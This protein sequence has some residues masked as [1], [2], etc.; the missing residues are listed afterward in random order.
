MQEFQCPKPAV[1]TTE[2]RGDLVTAQDRALEPR[3]YWFL[4]GIVLI[5]IVAAL[6]GTFSAMV[7]IWV[8]AETFNH[9][10]LIAPASIYLV[11]PHRKQLA[12]ITPLPSLAG[13]AA[14]GI[15]TGV[16]ML[17]DLA[18]TVVVQNFAAVALAPLS[19]WAILGTR[20]ARK[21]MFPLGYLFFMVP[22][23]YVLIP[24]LMDYTADFTVIAV[25][26][27]GVPVYRDGL[28][29]MIPGGSF[30]IVEAC[31]GIRMLIAA[32]AIGALFAY[33][34]F[35][36]WWR[37]L[38][39]ILGAAGLAI[40][41][42][43]MRAYTIVM[44][45]HYRGMDTIADHILLGYVIFAFIIVLMLMIGSRFSDIDTQPAPVIGSGAPGTI[46]GPAKHLLFAA[47]IVAIVAIT[48]FYAA[49]LKLH[50]AVTVTPTLTLP[51]ATDGWSG[52]ETVELNWAPQFIGQTS[53]LHGRYQ[54]RAA[55]VD[56]YVISYLSQTEGAEL[57]N[58][59]NQMF[60]RK[61]WLL[62]RDATGTAR[63]ADGKSLDY[64]E[65]E[66]YSTTGSRRLVRYWY[67]VDGRPQLS[68]FAVKLRELGNTLIGRPTSG[69]LV[70][71]SSHAA[72]GTASA[73]RTLD[74]FM[75]ATL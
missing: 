65:I 6:S 74:D 37:R 32:V 3:F 64:R 22:V 9:C 23:G 29:F 50:S 18:S 69:S 58:T 71:V 28:I 20:I 17:G 66:I 8:E 26:A 34:N 72:G 45:G 75:A 52:P 68:Q 4:A 12:A 70:A 14:V 19:I 21:I 30:K 35:Y 24:P 57:I 62:I 41:A 42:N 40:L 10:F 55:A 73:R 67:V 39:F 43:G 15:A 48:P 53:I 49:N 11:W 54:H 61:H 7:K 16:W 60:D 46:P 31:S 59:R 5:S 1:Q 44:L 13:L 47:V 38:V 2:P 63:T 36:S 51:A 56:M 27:S 33:L 25:R